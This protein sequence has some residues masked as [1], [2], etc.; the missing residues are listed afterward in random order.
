MYRVILQIELHYLPATILLRINKYP[1]NDKTTTF[2][3]LI[4]QNK[5]RLGLLHNTL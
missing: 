5:P 1:I 2:D 3:I 4:S